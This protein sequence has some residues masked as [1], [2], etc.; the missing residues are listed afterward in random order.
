[1]FYTNIFIKE[2]LNGKGVADKA[3]WVKSHGTMAK[4]PKH[5]ITQQETHK[6]KHFKHNYNFIWNKFFR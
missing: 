6:T 3:K 5:E 1:M 2:T 4:R